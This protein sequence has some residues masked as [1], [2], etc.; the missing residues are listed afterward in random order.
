[1]KGGREAAAEGRAAGVPS[2]AGDGE[3]GGRGYA[4]SPKSQNAEYGQRRDEAVSV[5]GVRAFSF[6][7][8][9][10]ARKKMAS[11]FGTLQVGYVYLLT[12]GAV[13]DFVKVGMTTR[14]PKERAREVPPKPCS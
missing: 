11:D 14:S 2:G 13:P 9:R 3:Q 8:P 5:T 10:V 12:N 1:M 6:S 7:A 4:L